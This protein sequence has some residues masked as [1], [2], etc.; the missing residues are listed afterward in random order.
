MM[1]S[2]QVEVRRSPADWGRGGWWVGGGHSSGVRF[3]VRVGG[4]LPWLGRVGGGG[5]GGGGAVLAAG[6][7]VG[8]QELEEV[9]VREFLLAGEGEPVGEDGEELAEFEGAQVPFEVG[10]DRVGEGHRVSFRAGV[11]SSWPGRGAAVAGR[12]R[13][14]V[15]VLPAAAGGG[16]AG[17]GG[18]GGPQQRPAGRRAGRRP[19]RRPRRGPARS[20]RRPRPGPPRPGLRRPRGRRPRPADRRGRR[21]GPARR[22]AARPAGSSRPACRRGSPRPG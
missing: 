10:A 12:R 9:G 20:A 7:L 21:A 17:G 11:V 3:G 2:W 4:F 1:S 16:A 14:A 19:G 18:G 15:P 6:D 8:E 22:T 5:G 13:G